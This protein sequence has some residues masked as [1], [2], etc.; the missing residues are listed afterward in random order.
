MRYVPRTKKERLE[1]VNAQI[2]AKI[3]KGYTLETYEGLRILT[4]DEDQH[5]TVCVYKDA[6]AHPIAYH[7][8]RSIDQRSTAIENIKKSYDRNKAYKAELKANPTKSSAANC[9]QAIREELAKVFPGVKFKVTS[10]NF[11]GGDSVHISWTDGPLSSQVEEVTGKYQYGHFNGMEDLYEYSNSREDIPQTKYVSESR[12]MSEETCTIVEASAEELYQAD[13][14]RMANYGCH[15]S[16]N[17]AR[18]VF[19]HTALPVGAKVLGIK[20]ND[21]TSGLCA[22]ETFYYVA[23]ELP[24]APQ[25]KNAPEF[26]E[27]EVKPGTVQ[28]IDYSEKAIAVIGDTKPIKDK[29]K[30]LGGKFNFRLSCGAGWIFSKKRLDEVTRALSVKDEPKALPPAEGKNLLAELAKK[31]QPL[32]DEI[33]KTVEWFAEVDKQNNGEISESTKEIARIQNVNLPEDVKQYD[34]LEDIERAANSG[35]VIDLMNL[36]QLVNAR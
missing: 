18:R 27:V 30:A 1:L 36:H 6:A 15:T 2:Q 5:F 16:G 31:H 11:A 20:R 23:Y 14:E 21:K 10:Q 19:Q 22:P 9:A 8:Y 34:T 28:I 26:E 17:F 35:Q 7:Y 25:T 13:P 32:K 4:K 33:Q 3:E 12:S 29:L 24:E